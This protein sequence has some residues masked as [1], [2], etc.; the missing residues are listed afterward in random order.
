MGNEAAS[1]A[2]YI[3]GGLLVFGLAVVGWAV[4]HPTTGGVADGD[5]ERKARDGGG[6][7]GDAIEGM[8]PEEDEEDDDAGSALYAFPPRPADHVS[9]PLESDCELAVVT[10]LDPA[11]LVERIK[12]KAIAASLTAA[13]CGKEAECNDVR[14]LIVERRRFTA[15]VV[16][17]ENWILPPRESADV[18]APALSSTELDRLYAMPKVI[19]LHARAPSDRRH[20]PVRAGFAAASALAKQ[21]NGF[22]YDEV[23]HRIESAEAFS[24]HAVT[25]T[26]AEGAFRADRFVV[27]SYDDGPDGGTPSI[28]LLTLGFQRFGAPDLI[29]EGASLRAER[30][31]GALLY[32][33][34]EALSKGARGKTVTLSKEVLAI[35]LGVPAEEL[36]APVEVLFTD[37]DRAAGDADNLLVRLVPAGYGVARGDAGPTKAEAQK[38]L[39]DLVNKVFPRK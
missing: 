12:P 26:F 11:K 32:G 19:V 33:A 36:K 18:V 24:K 6:A 10:D 21:L 27:Q 13:D 15:E 28:R 34:G 4:T 14:A 31:A 23:L 16:P 25:E 37:A 38:A 29:V 1:R 17:V 8:D 3:V 7:A 2:P 20:L 35:G 9:A 5:A 30:P 22:V 39:D